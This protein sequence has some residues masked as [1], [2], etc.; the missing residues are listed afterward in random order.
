M[1]P[2]TA[3]R[4]EDRTTATVSP[5]SSIFKEQ[6]QRF[7]GGCKRTRTFSDQLKRLVPVQSGAAPYLLVGS[8]GIE[9][10]T[11]G[12]KARCSTVEP[13]PHS[14]VADF[15]FIRLFIVLS[16]LSWWSVVG[17]EPHT[18]KGTGLQPVS[19]YR[20]PNHAP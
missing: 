11:V 2:I 8:V 3:A 12:L 19:F 17:V 10:T 14:R 1:N 4:P 20:K 6:R 7:Y 9:P 5:K 18:P 16:S 13:R 15:R